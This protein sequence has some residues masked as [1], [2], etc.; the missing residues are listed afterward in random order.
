MTGNI[1]CVK[2]NRDQPLYAHKMCRN[3]YHRKL[4]Q[5]HPDRHRA[6]ARRGR[7]SMTI[8]DRRRKKDY[9]RQWALA[10]AE[11]LKADKAKWYH[12]LPWYRRNKMAGAARGKRLSAE[13]LKTLQE[14][15]TVCSIP[16]CGTILDYAISAKQQPNQATL[17]KV[18]PARGY[19]EDNVQI[20]CRS[21]NSTKVHGTMKDWMRFTQY[22]MAHEHHRLGNR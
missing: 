10:N 22:V 5:A 20:I 2:C 6:Y 7:E 18:I 3:C 17:D 1:I 9:M 19:V 21:C 14:S 13:F 11:K 15:T 12:N 8:E 16:G 4:R